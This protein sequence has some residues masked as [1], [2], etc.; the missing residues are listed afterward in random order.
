MHNVVWEGARSC[1]E[2]RGGNVRVS[3]MQ[4]EKNKNL[5]FRRRGTIK[6]FRKHAGGGLTTMS[7][8]AAQPEQASDSTLELLVPT[9]PDGFSWCTYQ[10]AHP[11]SARAFLETT[12]T[13]TERDE[14]KSS[15]CKK[16]ETG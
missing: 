8:T 2:G 7:S 4:R 10:T 15:I 14:W 11:E 16:K 1:Q 6:C 3:I 12:L 13:K 9:W 5:I